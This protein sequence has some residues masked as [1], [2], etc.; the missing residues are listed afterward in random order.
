VLLALIAVHVAAIVIY[1]LLI[2]RKLT[3]AMFTGRAELEP[4][5]EPMRLAKWWVAIICLLAAL[6]VS[7]WVVDGAPLPG[8]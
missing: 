7:R 8:T 2:G 3:G 5:V 6:A 4:G 1:R